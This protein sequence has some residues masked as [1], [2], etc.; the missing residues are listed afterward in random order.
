MKSL[1]TKNVLRERI[2]EKEL[3]VDD[4]GYS[5]FNIMRIN[6]EDYSYECSRVIKDENYKVEKFNFAR[7]EEDKLVDGC[8]FDAVFKNVVYKDFV[9]GLRK[10]VDKDLFEY[11]LLNISP[12]NVYMNQDKFMCTED[13]EIILIQSQNSS[14][15]FTCKKGK[16]YEDIIHDIID[17]RS[18]ILYLSYHDEE[19]NLKN[20]ND[21]TYRQVDS[22]SLDKKVNMVYASSS[23][24]K[25]L[26][27]YEYY[28]SGIKLIKYSNPV[29]G[30]K[31]NKNGLYID[32]V[33]IIQP[34][35][36][37]GMLANK[38]GV[39]SYGD[40]IYHVKMTLNDLVIITLYKAGNVYINRFIF[41]LSNYQFNYSDIS[42]IEVA[43]YIQ[44]E[45]N[46]YTE[47]GKFYENVKY[48]G[49]V[50]KEIYFYENHID[51]KCKDEFYVKSRFLFTDDEDIY[52][53]DFLYGIPSIPVLNIKE[54]HQEFMK[55][56]ISVDA[57]EKVKF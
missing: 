34:N 1:F 26:V 19:L 35:T 36:I 39:Y 57:V 51:P 47:E 55:R 30:I 31:Y 54:P 12:N 21:G 48:Y 33:E 27:E 8:Q 16:Q 4:I 49:D 24:S 23:L 37:E 10:I 9:L 28:P 14:N 17:E 40:G 41:N 25:E 53:R 22:L 52:M 44:Y 50:D 46:S 3:S 6:P 32:D 5:V 38:D 20:H 43:G 7:T 42:G 15:V 13:S 2:I 11:Y 18:D 56:H 29:T 45:S